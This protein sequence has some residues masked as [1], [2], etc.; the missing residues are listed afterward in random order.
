MTRRFLACL[1]AAFTLSGCAGP[2]LTE[3]RQGWAAACRS[4]GFAR[5]DALLSCMEQRQT[6]WNASRLATAQVQSAYAP[7]NLTVNKGYGW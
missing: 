6:A 7:N 3:L 1:F 2:S 4:E 5:Q